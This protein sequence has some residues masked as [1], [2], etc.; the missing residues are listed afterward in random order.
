M[1]KDIADV[2]SKVEESEQETEENIA[3]ANEIFE[4]ND[5]ITEDVDVDLSE[6]V[7]ESKNEINQTKRGLLDRRISL[8]NNKS[9]IIKELIGRK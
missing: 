4:E 6:E 8:E 3:K 1:A 7:L 5:E 2:P 9:K